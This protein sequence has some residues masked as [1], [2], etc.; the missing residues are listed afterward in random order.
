MESQSLRT[1]GGLLLP[2][3]RTASDALR[4][5]VMRFGVH[6]TVRPQIMQLVR[7]RMQFQSTISREFGAAACFLLDGQLRNGVAAL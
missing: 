5:L 4:G 1:F 6:C 7:A 2:E 3:K